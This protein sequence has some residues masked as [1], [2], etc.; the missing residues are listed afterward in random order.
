MRRCLLQAGEVAESRMGAAVSIEQSN[1]P[2]A[3]E[4][5]KRMSTRRPRSAAAILPAARLGNLPAPTYVWARELSPGV[6]PQEK[7]GTKR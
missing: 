3:C 2:Y 6:G 7:K 4:D 5:V 1:V